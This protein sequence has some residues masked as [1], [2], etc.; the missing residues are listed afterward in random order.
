MSSAAFAAAVE[1]F[2]HARGSSVECLRQAI[3]VHNDILA[4]EMSAT[5]DLQLS[6]ADTE[7]GPDTALVITGFKN[8]DE[9]QVFVARLHAPR[10]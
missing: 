4:Q 10:K 7:A 1:R 3:K 8:V 6:V 5:S 2:M 9:I